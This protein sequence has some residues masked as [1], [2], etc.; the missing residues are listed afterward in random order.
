MKQKMKEVMMLKQFFDQ[1]NVYIVDQAI[2]AMETRFKQL[3]A[4]NDYFGFLF[5]IGKLT[6]M[7]DIDVL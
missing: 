1:N 5:R 7:A 4:Y 2:S 6:E 3:E